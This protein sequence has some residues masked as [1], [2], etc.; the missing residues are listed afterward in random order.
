[1]S[2]QR[3]YVALAPHDDDGE[4]E[5]DLVS[6]FSEQLGSG[7]ES[8]GEF[9]RA[10]DCRPRRDDDRA[11]LVGIEIV[12]VESDGSTVTIHYD[13]EFFA[14]Y[15]CKDVDGSYIEDGLVLQGVRDGDHWAFSV[16]EYPERQ[17]P[18][19]EF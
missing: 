4:A 17:A 13:V 3:I 16:H 19:E 10:F 9:A 11:S 6:Y 15:A 2:D 14:Y 12:E 18:D 5:I 1:M 8:Y 7:P